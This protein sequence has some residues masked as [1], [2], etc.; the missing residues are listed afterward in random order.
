MRRRGG[1][2]NL[3]RKRGQCDEIHTDMGDKPITKAR[4]FDSGASS[5]KETRADPEKTPDRSNSESGKSASEKESKSNSP[6]SI[7][8][9][10]PDSEDG[11]ERVWMPRLSDVDDWDDWVS[12]NKKY[13]EEIHQSRGFEVTC[14]PYYALTTCF[15]PWTFKE[16]TQRSTPE[17]IVQWCHDS[18]AQFNKVHCSQKKQGYPPYEFVEVE[19]ITC[20]RAGFGYYI[21]YI[22]F[23]AKAASSSIVHC[24]VFRARYAILKKAGSA[25]FFKVGVLSCE[26]KS[27]HDARW[28]EKLAKKGGRCLLPC[29]IGK[30]PPISRRLSDGDRIQ[31]R[32]EPQLYDK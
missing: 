14:C 9:S 12:L 31:V 29:C 2:T 26:L 22:T 1:Y 13:R 25:S 6:T 27:E 11:Q 24:E 16:K 32:R 10:P 28:K 4:Q 8:P 19:Y 5:D 30:Y 7:E 23:K 21:F 18:I 20:I 3:K 17:Q 15:V